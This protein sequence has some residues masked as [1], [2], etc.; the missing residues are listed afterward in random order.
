MAQFDVCRVSGLRDGSAV[1]LALILQNDILDDTSTRV[2]APVIEVDRRRQTTKTAP[3]I[4]IDGV[5]YMIAMNLVMT[6]PRRNLG[7]PIA[8]L[9]NEEHVLKK[10]IDMVFYGV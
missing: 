4:E 8:N 10:A 3:I 9:K 5:H 7:R 6:V 2:V 1:D